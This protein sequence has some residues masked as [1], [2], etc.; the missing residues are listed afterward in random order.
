MELEVMM[1]DRLP[2]VMMVLTLNMLLMVDIGVELFILL[3]M[4]LILVELLEVMDIVRICRMEQ[5]Y[6]MEA[7][8]RKE[9]IWSYLQKFKWVNNILVK[10]TVNFESLLKV[11][12][13]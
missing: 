10:E 12:I 4:H 11:M 9:L 3:L 1:Q 13:Q 6:L 8:F 7:Q 5:P 2:I